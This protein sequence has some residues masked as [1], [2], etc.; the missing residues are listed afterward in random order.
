MV[1]ET[2]PSTISAQVVCKSCG[3][4]YPTEASDVP[5]PSG[6]GWECG[7]CLD[8]KHVRLLAELKEKAR[9]KALE[10]EEREAAKR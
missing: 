2:R 3:S 7:P 9:L 10:R 8:N 6:N 5:V 4:P 1:E